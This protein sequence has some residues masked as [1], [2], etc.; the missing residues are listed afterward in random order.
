MLDFIHNYMEIDGIPISRTS[1]D[2]M[3]YLKN[4]GYTIN[5][6]K[7]VIGRTVSKGFI[8]CISNLNGNKIYI[9]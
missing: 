5:E 7:G 3:E 8:R 1:S 2:C 6:S 4:R 9:S